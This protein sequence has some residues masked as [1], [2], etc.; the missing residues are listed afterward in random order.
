VVRSAGNDGWA[1]ALRPPLV[2][3]Q[4]Q[5]SSWTTGKNVL[6]VGSTYND[7]P[8]EDNQ[9]DYSLAK[10]DTKLNTIAT[11]SSR[12]P[13]LKTG[14][15]KPD[16]VA[17]GN[18][19]LSVRCSLTTVSVQD[20][21]GMWTYLHGSF[22]GDPKPTDKLIICSGTFQ[23]CPAV[24]GC[25]ALI[26]EAFEKWHNFK[27]PSAALMKVLL[28]NG[29]DDLGVSSNLQGFG[30]VN[31]YQALRPLG[32]PTSSTAKTT[33]IPGSGFAF[34]TVLLHHLNQVIPHKT[35]VPAKTL[36]SKKLNFVATIIYHDYKGSEIN[37]Q[38]N[39]IVTYKN[40]KKET[41]NYTDTAANHENVLRIMLPD[42]VT[43]EN[44]SIGMQLKLLSAGT[45]VPWGLAWDHFET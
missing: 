21:L 34:G 25:A 42:V 7:R 23:A 39:L 33:P 10:S 18:G 27:T 45:S 36:S 30:Q 24:S 20:N 43:G 11:S 17:P 13:V 22:P 1:A 6:T 9:V 40:V 19:I 41:F 16:V 12:G 32:P 3:V 44:I 5:I 15:T 4:A 8:T 14:R 26:G 38:M 2:S 29:A 28:I 37:N 35:V 31:L